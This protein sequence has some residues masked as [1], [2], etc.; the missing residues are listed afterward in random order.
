ME[1]KII[2]DANLY[3]VYSSLIQEYL[4]SKHL[5]GIPESE[6]ITNTSE[7]YL[8]HSYVLRKD[9]CST[10]VRIVFHG[11]SRYSEKL[12]VN[13]ALFTGPKLQ[14]N[15]IS[16]ILRFR[17]YKYVFCANIRQMYRMIE[18]SAEH[19]NYL[20]LFWRFLPNEPLRD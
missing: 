11:S 9:S 16:I 18:I 2:K 5:E 13:D 17:L 19:R 1:S 6:L 12:S 4:E 14:N 8:P 20:R 7:F 3:S 10:P 15:L